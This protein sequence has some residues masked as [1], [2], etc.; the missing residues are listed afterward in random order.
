VKLSAAQRSAVR[1]IEVIC[2]RETD[3]RMLRERV[4]DRLSRLLYWD[5]ACFA[6]VDPLTM[7]ITDDLSYGL[8]PNA[9]AHAAHNEY[10]VD[11]L[12][13]IAKLAKSP[14]H[15]GILG[16]VPGELRETS[17]RARTV[18]P[19]L[20]MRHEA[21]AACVAS[22]ECWG[23][24]AMFRSGDAEDFSPADAALLH[25]LSAPLAAGLRRTTRRT[26]ADP[27]ESGKPGPGVLILGT[28]NETLAA[29][30]AARRWLAEM[31]PAGAGRGGELPMVVHQVAAGVRPDRP[32]WAPEAYARVRTRA[33]RWATVH[34][35]LVEGGL[36]P[37]T[38]TS[39]VIESAPASDIMEI[40]MSAYQLTRRERVVL[41]RV[42]AGFPST[43]IAA[44][45]HISAS[46]VQDHLKS[47]FAKV[48]VRSRGQLVARLLEE[49][50]LP[51]TST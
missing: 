3:S 40:L 15:V 17:Q 38:G 10:L 4:A 22:G 14:M 35:S 27:T 50:Y 39:V 28:H 46:T 1:D 21:R 25:A 44:Q 34:A 24:I 42:I 11:D 43:A 6:N 29:N 20:G 8:P 33:G 36:A 32:G 41:Q 23:A 7:L 30:D 49:H 18:L 9:Y 47:I 37:G 16:Q 13:K 31:T 51:P 12:H 45:L 5:A 48:G 2:S 19:A 26:G